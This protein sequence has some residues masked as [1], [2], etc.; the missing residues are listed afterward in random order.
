MQN[1][2]FQE[3]RR[4]N[5]QSQVSIRPCGEAASVPKPPERLALQ[6]TVSNDHFSI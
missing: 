3:V 4:H 2:N 1:D 5:L 6:L